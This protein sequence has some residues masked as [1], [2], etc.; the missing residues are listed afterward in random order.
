MNRIFPIAVIAA[1]IAFSAA[2]L[3]HRT[4]PSWHE[5]PRRQVAQQVA[6]YEPQAPPLPEK[7]SF[8]IA[9]FNIYGVPEKLII[10]CD[11]KRGC[12]PVMEM[13]ITF[14]FPEVKSGR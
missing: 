14:T 12:Y 8:S 10:E 6:P 9:Q 7:F 5:E 1:I 4:A 11:S 3:I 2:V 13:D